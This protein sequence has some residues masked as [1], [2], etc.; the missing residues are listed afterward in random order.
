MQSL[1][2]K[3]DFDRVYREGVKRVGRYVVLYLLPADDN[4][5]AVV[6]SRKIGGAVKRN[7]AKRL[8]R[9]A[10]RRHLDE[11]SGG[12]S[13]IRQRLIPARENGTND[14]QGRGLWI[15]CV[16]RHRILEVTSTDVRQELARLL[17]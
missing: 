8:I 2:R 5:R 4:A 7:R 12:T 16:A 9:E 6:A 15:V 14:D 13:A 1:R 17:T 11:E 10:L 3:S